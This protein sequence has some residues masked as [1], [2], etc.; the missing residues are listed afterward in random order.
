MGPFNSFFTHTLRFFSQ[1]RWSKI[2][3]RMPG[4]TD[5][6]IKNRWNTYIK[7]KLVTMGIDPVTHKPLPQEQ[8]AHT[9]DHRSSSTASQQPA[10]S[11]SSQVTTCSVE[12]SSGKNFQLLPNIFD[13]ENTEFPLLNHLWSEEMSTTQLMDAGSLGFPCEDELSDIVGEENKEFTW[14][15]DYAENGFMDSFELR[16]NK[17]NNEN[18]Q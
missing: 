13:D 15:M 6:D 14:L 1:C 4:R 10:S 16:C 2:A 3:A 12:N 9:S 5:N 17:E 18:K 11:V 8:F 7:K